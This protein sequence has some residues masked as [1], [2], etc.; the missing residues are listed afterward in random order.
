MGVIVGLLAGSGVFCVW[1][2]FWVPSR[3][4]DP[5]RPGLLSRAREV[6]VQA[7]LPSVSPQ[8]L[9]LTGLGLGLIGFVG[10]FALSGY[11]RLRSASGRWP[12][13]SR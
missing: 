10:V 8:A 7:G 6:L 11:R 5:G 9:A 12:P 2:S 4:R 1:W 3:S 13:G